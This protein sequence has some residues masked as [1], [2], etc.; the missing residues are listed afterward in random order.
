MKDKILNF[1]KR[2]YKITLILVLAFALRAYGIYFDYPNGV[3]FVWDETNGITNLLEALEQ[4]SLFVSSSIYPILMLILY[5]PVLLLR[6]IYIAIREGIFNLVEIKGFLIA[7]GIGQI[8]IITRWF[9]VVMGTLAVYLIYRIYKLIFKHEQSYYVASLA[10]A[11]SIVPVFLSHW[12]KVHGLMV[13]FL[14][15]SLLFALLFEKEKKLK[16]FYLSVVAAACSVSLHYMGVS[17]FIFPFLALAYNWKLVSWKKALIAFF[18]FSSIVVVCYLIT[19]KGVINMFSKIVVNYSEAGS[20]SGSAG[21]GFFERLYFMFKG[22]FQLEP[23]FLIIF[24]VMLVLNIKKY[25]KHKMSSYILYGILFNYILMV[26][27]FA[28]PFESKFWIIFISLAIPLGV[29]SLVE[30][31][32]NR[33]WKNISV[34]IISVLLLIQPFFLTLHWLRLLNTHTSKE[35]V[36]WLEENLESDQYAYTFDKHLDA[37]LSYEAA[38]WHKENNKVNDSKKI[39]YILSHEEEFLDRGV[40]LIYDHNNFRYED[41]AGENTKYIVVYY[42]QRNSYKNGTFWAKRESAEMVI[43]EIKKYHDIVLVKTFYPTDKKRLIQS[44]IM[45]QINNP[46]DLLEIIQ[47]EKS[48]PFMEIYEILDYNKAL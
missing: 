31:M 43:D 37:E 47:L 26:S 6:L 24:F 27:V 3:N 11:I 38:L 21:V 30:F 25:L 14:I 41:L 48:G 17:S 9:S 29:G 12:G 39:N 32:K 44:G 16:F 46:V 10:Y 8:Y 15:L 34:C 18:I 20:F 28:V 19:Y 35:T 33:Q 13:F 1:V 45:D 7:N 2:H 36:E 40:N 23:I 4:K 22:Y 42:W 5:L